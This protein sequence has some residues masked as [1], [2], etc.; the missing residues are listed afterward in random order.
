MG[1]ARQRGKRA[2]SSLSLYSDHLTWPQA[3]SVDPS[4]DGQDDTL[5]S[6]KQVKKL[7]L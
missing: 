1:T 5:D 6:S 2:K 7:S 4:S 3:S